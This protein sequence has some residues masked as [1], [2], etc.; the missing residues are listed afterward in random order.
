MG[1]IQDSR[2]EQ[3]S[4]YTWSDLTPHQWQCFHLALFEMDAEIKAQ[5]VLV[6]QC[7]A[8]FEVDSELVVSGVKIVQS[9][10][11]FEAEGELIVT[12]TMSTNDYF[13]RMIR[14]LP[15]YERKSSVFK[16]IMKA[17]DREF[18]NLEQ[19]KNVVELNS[20]VD[21]A[22][23]SLALHEKDLRIRAG[24]TL[25]QRR[26][27]IIARYMISF[28]QT[29]EELIRNVCRIYTDSAIS[30]DVTD[31]NGLWEI[32][33]VDLKGIP[34]L[35]DELV[36]VMDI[37]LPAHLGVGYKFIYNTWGDVRSM[38]WGDARELTWDEIRVYLVDGMRWS[39]V[40]DVSWWDGRGSIWNEKK[41]IGVME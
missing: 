12:N 30:L 8:T 5:G 37:L 38:T 7:G 4:A 10:V 39:D 19:L 20:F 41:R 16:E 27:Q 25:K 15:K 14:Y 28:Q 35:H 29:T 21:S 33:F 40:A 26:A 11:M 34:E 6:E 18:R 1:P 36:L 24:T 31:I 23:E 9:S 22:I 13:T 32:T 2:W 17:D 3:I